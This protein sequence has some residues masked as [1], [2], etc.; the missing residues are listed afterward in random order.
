MV[1]KHLLH[2]LRLTGTQQARIDEDACEL[3][4]DRFVQENG[5]HRRIDTARQA[6]DDT[7]LADLACECW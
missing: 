7:F 5:G 1:A 4:A 6:A 3:I 2:V